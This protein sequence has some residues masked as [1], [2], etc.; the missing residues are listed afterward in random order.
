MGLYGSEAWNLKKQDSKST[1][2]SELWLEETPKNAMDSQENKPIVGS[3]EDS[4]DRE[5]RSVT[6]ATRKEGGI[7]KKLLRHL[8]IHIMIKGEEINYNQTCKFGV[9][10]KMEI[11]PRNQLD[12]QTKIIF[13]NIAME[14]CL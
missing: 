11:R 9:S 5:G 8:P 3:K 7:Q 4:L 1:D 10:S 14:S 13:I 12:I 6:K 2:A